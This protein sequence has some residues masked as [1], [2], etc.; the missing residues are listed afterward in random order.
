MEGG[1]TITILFLWLS[2]EDG[3]DK[4][5][6][7]RVLMGFAAAALFWGMKTG[8][9]DC[10]GLTAFLP[11]IFLAG[12]SMMTGGQVGQGDVVLFFALGFT[13]DPER[14]FILCMESFGLAGIF[15][16][17]VWLTDRKETRNDFAFIPF[18][19]ASWIRQYVF[20]IAGVGG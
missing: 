5:V 16:F 13:L 2:W 17:V 7:G 3:K 20:L 11:G 19:A 8:K 14:V 1:E 9:K 4:T 12:I 18:A 10:F 6:D 15:G